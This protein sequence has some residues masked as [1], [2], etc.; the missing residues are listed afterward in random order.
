MRAGLWEREARL[1]Q[2]KE[3]DFN[4]VYRLAEEQSVIGLVAA[5][6]D[7][8][9]DI[10]AP[11]EIVLQFVGTALQL[12]R[13][14]TAMNKFIGE[15]LDKMKRSF[16]IFDDSAEDITLLWTVDKDFEKKM[17]KKVLRGGSIVRGRVRR[18][19]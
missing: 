13:Q 8:V 19:G 5:G 2:F 9:K 7:H 1:L 17:R 10:K 15:M 18:T 12:E 16:A 4:E 6:L 14:N 3:I 11:K